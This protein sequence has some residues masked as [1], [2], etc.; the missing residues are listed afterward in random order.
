M[1]WYAKKGVRKPGEEQPSAGGILKIR[2]PFV[3]YP[4][5]LPDFVQGAILC[6]VPMGITAAMTDVLGIPF[7][8]GI[9]MVL[10][11][12][13]MYLLH[14]SFGDPSVV[15]WITPGIPLF[16]AFVTNY[17]P[18]VDRIHALMALQLLVAIIFLFL[19]VTGLAQKV[20][21]R[22]PIS[23]KSGILMGAAIA[24]IRGEFA[25]G[26]RIEAMPF[27]IL[28]GLLV[29]FFVL[30]SKSTTILRNR[31][32]PFRYVAQFGIAIPFFLSYI[33]AMVIGEVTVPVVQGGMT[34]TPFPDAWAMLSPFSIGFPPAHMF[35]A[36]LPLALAAYVIA[37]GDV[38]VATGLLKEADEVRT[39]EKVIFYVNRNHI[40]TS[41]RNF[42][43]ALLHPYLPLS[44]P[45]WAAG[46][47]LV[48]NRY[49]NATPE[50]QDTYW[51]GAT[52][53]FW[54]MSIAL[55][56]NPLVTFFRPG[57]AIGFSLT[58]LLQGFLCG[59][60][61]MNM[62]DNNIQRGISITMGV[63][64]SV[65]GAAEALALGL[66]FSLLLEWKWIK[67][68]EELEAAKNG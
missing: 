64:L 65:R 60:I 28:F 38:L 5:E 33:F 42:I 4:F 14:T 68:D 25:P 10:L 66:A 1:T 18:G 40:I 8:I 35:M 47:A 53:V 30:F 56:L 54:G 44:G 31:Y 27:S 36:A 58:L 32:K 41:A 19:G 43:H 61:A 46:Q 62:V 9:A 26:G 13:F 52:S 20:V 24:S 7:E 63:V 48:V 17:E 49:M 21:D 16:L 3:H 37:F 15:G 34:P 59:Y 57:L 2:L 23:M 29:S 67:S 50:E 55:A 11:N 12:N 39:D 22:I 45:Q 6:V 51:G